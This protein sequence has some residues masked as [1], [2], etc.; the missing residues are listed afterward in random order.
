MKSLFPCLPL[1]LFGALASTTSGSE[2]KLPPRPVL[3][4]KEAVE[5]EA[6]PFDQADVRLLDSA[7]KQ[8]MEK[9]KE[10]LLRLDPKRLLA[11]FEKQAGLL[12]GDPY[13]GWDRKGMGPGAGQWGIGHYL[14]ACSEMYRASGDARFLERVNMVVE[15]LAK[16]QKLEGNAGLIISDKEKKGYAEIAAGDV[17]ADG[18][19]VLN[20]MF[21]PLYGL[22]KPMA[23]LLDAWTLCGN[24]QAREV[25]LK[26]VDW[27]ESL[28][29]NLDDAQMQALLSVEHGGIAETL[30]HVYALTGEARHLTLARRFR[31][32]KFFLPMA[33]GND[34]LSSFHANTQVPKFVGYQRLFELTGEA[35]WGEAALNFWTFVSRDRSFANGG[36]SLHEHFNPLDRFEDAMSDTEGPETCNTYNMLKLTRDL[37]ARTADAAKMDFFERG[38]YNQILPSQHPQAGGFTYFQALVPGGYRT[39]SDLDRDFWCCVGTGMENHAI[40]GKGIYAHRGDRLFVNLFIPSE[41]SWREQ[42]VNVTQQTVFPDEPR[43]R[44]QVKLANPKKFTVAVRYPGWV[45]PGALKLA[46]N[47]EA[48]PTNARPGGFGEVTRTWKDGDTLTVELPMTLRTEMLPNSK[49]YVSIFYGPILLAAKLGTEGLSPEDFRIRVMPAIKRLPAAQTPVIVVPVSAIPEWLEP[50]AGQSLVF[51]SRNMLK[52]ADL[53]FVPLNRIFDERYSM[54]F[55]V[56]S[57]STWE[58]DLE[59]WTGEEQAERELLARMIDEVR[60]GEQQPEIDHGIKSDRSKTSMRP[61]VG[62]GFREA[63]NGGWFSVDLKVDPAKPMELLCTYWGSDAD[64]R[65]FDIVVGDKVIASQQ[66]TGEKPN[67]FVQK[68]YPIPAELTQ[69]KNSVT[70]KFLAKPGKVAGAVYDCR[71]LSQR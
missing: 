38:L 27:V 19:A 71:M 68:V 43:T 15:T 40:Y 53:T 14:S 18:K 58:Q 7:F 34:M 21:V 35:E 52:P 63:V 64:H 26:T 67:E 56:T 62:R 3:A 6:E 54:Y 32:D 17:K 1:V 50:V 44:I 4:V 49:N 11:W 39:Y 25:L 22:H 20:G 5:Y 16:C 65:E 69:G 24:S 42:G 55:R 36:N 47:N 31:D 60:F 61:A 8:A 9:D 59:R 2:A 70:V 51:K 29:K 33:A 45:A 37:F 23:G 12:Q 30:A 41:L 10:Y 48:I 28:I 57:P 66:L 46:V 13:L